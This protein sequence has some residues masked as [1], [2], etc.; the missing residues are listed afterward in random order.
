[1]RIWLCG[2]ALLFS[3]SAHP[4]EAVPLAANPAL[5]ARVLA[6][7]GELRCLV[8]QNQSLLDSHSA[9]ADDLRREIRDLLSQGKSDKEVVDFM[10]SRY[11]D[12]VRYRPAFQ[13]NTLLLWLGPFL[14]LLTAGIV[15]YRYFKKS[16]SETQQ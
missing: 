3:V 4:G 6:L 14:L 10:V 8:C 5:E 9:L 15:L 12:F 2:I 13:Q 11:G 16:E 7:A 1:M